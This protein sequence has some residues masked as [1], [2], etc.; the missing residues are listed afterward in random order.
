VAWSPDGR[1]I[2]TVSLDRTARIWDPVSGTE[3]AVLRGHQDAVWGV[4]W[5]PDSQRLATVSLDRTARIWD[6]VSGTEL[7]VLR[8]H[9]NAVRG[10]AWSADGKRLATGSD[11]HTTRI[12][13]VARAWH[14]ADD[15]DALMARARTR[16]F[17]GLKENERRS[18]M[19]P[20]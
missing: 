20:G 12:W 3:L 13:D 9:Q 10:V 14:T 18:A 7:A 6:P 11:D 2:A 8:G 1:C 17:R 19:L 16:V 5:S 4:A 15:L